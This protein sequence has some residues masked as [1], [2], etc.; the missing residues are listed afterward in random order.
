V[1]NFG[2]TWLE[3]EQLILKS[4]IM[5]QL[6]MRKRFISEPKYLVGTGSIMLVLGIVL[7]RFFP[8]YA[9]TS[10]LS[11]VFLGMSVVF[12]LMA[13]YIYANRDKA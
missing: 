12:N 10:F 5:K 13:I 2:L 9:Y 3:I 11:G 4:N 6:S 7:G 1:N 8:E